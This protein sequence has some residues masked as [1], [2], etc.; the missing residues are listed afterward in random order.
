MRLFFSSLLLFLLPLLLF[1]P[2][3][4]LLDGFQIAFA[5]VGDVLFRELRGTVPGHLALDVS[6]A[7]PQIGCRMGGIPFLRVRIAGG[8][9]SVLITVSKSNIAC[10]RRRVSSLIVQPPAFWEI[11]E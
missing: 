9:C 11:P 1:L 4:H 10:R 3:F 8:P 5:H 7:P 6:G 2:L